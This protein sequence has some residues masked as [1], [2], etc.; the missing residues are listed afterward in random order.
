MK[1]EELG[2]FIQYPNPFGMG[3]HDTQKPRIDFQQ[4]RY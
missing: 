3:H 1:E 2:V 4:G